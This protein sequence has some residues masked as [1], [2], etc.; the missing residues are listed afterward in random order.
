MCF[1]RANITYINFD[2]ENMENKFDQITLSK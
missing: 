1:M 2:F